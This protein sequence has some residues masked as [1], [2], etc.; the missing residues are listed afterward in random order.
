MQGGNAGPTPAAM[1]PVVI[2]PIMKIGL[3]R[4]SD[5]SSLHG[6]NLC[7]DAAVVNPRPT[8]DSFDSIIQDWK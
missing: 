4:I 1:T 7:V 2:V 8:Y 5:T 6:S 3:Q